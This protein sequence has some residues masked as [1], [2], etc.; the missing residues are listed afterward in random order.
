MSFVSQASS[1]QIAAYFPNLCLDRLLKWLTL[2]P[3]IKHCFKVCSFSIDIFSTGFS[4]TVPL[5]GPLVS[6]HYST[7]YSEANAA[8][9]S[10]LEYVSRLHWHISVKKIYSFSGHISMLS[11]SH[12]LPQVSFPWTSPCSWGR[13]PV[14]TYLER[15]LFSSALTQ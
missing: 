12:P 2:T 11:V 15:V 10:L 5:F 8:A 13:Q 14:Y 3:E 1:D 7:I 6:F 9:S 4:I